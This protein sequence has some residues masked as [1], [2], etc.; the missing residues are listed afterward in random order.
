MSKFTVKESRLWVKE[1]LSELKARLGEPTSSRTPDGKLLNTSY[2]W[3]N[4]QMENGAIISA[5]LYPPCKGVNGRYTISPW[6]H[7]RVPTN[8]DESNYRIGQDNG[9]RN[10]HLYE[11]NS[12]SIDNAIIFSQGHIARSLRDAKPEIKP[13][14]NPALTPFVP[15]AWHNPVALH[16]HC[17]DSSNEVGQTFTVSSYTVDGTLVRECKD[18]ELS[19]LEAQGSRFIKLSA[20]DIVSLN[21]DGWS[22]D[23]LMEIHESNLTVGVNN[24]KIKEPL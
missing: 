15:R 20:A 22:R 4:I 23:S 16:I 14:D 12:Y 17:V 9:K 11:F 2:E 1:M 13:E 19:E 3:Q 18:V 8:V 7:I 21:E 10:V 5:S 24:E 6:V